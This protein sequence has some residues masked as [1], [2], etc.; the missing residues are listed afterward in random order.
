MAENF[1]LLPCRLVCYVDS[2]LAAELGVLFVIL[3]CAEYI[4]SN[5][6]YLKSCASGLMSDVHPT[7]MG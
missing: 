1:Q 4:L 2:A 6:L 3:Y 7:W 5:D